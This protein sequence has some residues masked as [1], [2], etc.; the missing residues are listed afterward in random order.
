M[1][2]CPRGR[3]RRA[4][5]GYLL[6]RCCAAL[7][8]CLHMHLCASA[9]CI[10]TSKPLP[11]SCRS[12]NPTPCLQ[13]ICLHAV[14]NRHRVFLMHQQVDTEP[15]CSLNTEPMPYRHALAWHGVYTRTF[16]R[17]LLPN[18]V[19]GKQ[20]ESTHPHA[21]QK[22][23]VSAV[24]IHR[25]AYNGRCSCGSDGEKQCFICSHIFSGTVAKE[26]RESC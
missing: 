7:Q 23:C 20:T 22:Q 14:I 16:P 10:L 26:Y 5:P 15:P 1:P 24:E 3:A 4:C 2:A 9:R 17:C 19:C 18:A 21:P 6:H 13:L 8:S 11:A 12:L 25:G